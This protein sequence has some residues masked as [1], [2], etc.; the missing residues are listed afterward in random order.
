MAIK[1]L[2]CS[3]RNFSKKKKNN[4]KKAAR[5]RRRL[6]WRK[7]SIYLAAI[8]TRFSLQC[9]YSYEFVYI[10]IIPWVVLYDHPFWFVIN[11]GIFIQWIFFLRSHYGMSLKLNACL[12]FNGKGIF[13]VF[14]C[15]I[16]EFF[17]YCR[18]IKCAF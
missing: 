12:S 1:E 6:L 2:E 10:Y 18:S 4:K 13:V 7:S 11:A 14:D 5:K 3:N 17:Y 16:G 15:I 9:S 8:W